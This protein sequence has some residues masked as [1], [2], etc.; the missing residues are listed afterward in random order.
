MRITVRHETRYDYDSELSYAV[1]RLCLTPASFESQKVSS[2]RISAPGIESA[3]NY[4]D[5]F[6]NRI[7]LI[8]YGASDS[9]ISIVAEGTVDVTDSAGIIRRLP[10]AVPDAVFLR[11][12]GAT[13]PNEPMA[14]MAQDVPATSPL[15]RMHALMAEIHRHVEYEIGATHAHTTGAE[16]F[17]EGKGV[18]Q[19]HAHIM[20]GLA[21]YW[22]IPARYVTGYLVTG[23][24]TS[25]T[26]AHAWAE[27][28]IPN[29]GWVGF[30]AANCKCPT[31]HYVRVASGIDAGAVTPVRGSRRGG[32]GERMKV[33][34]RVEI[35]QQ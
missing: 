29:L 9:P 8:T 20:I 32:T 33:E 31:D 1:Q 28:L 5:G 26:A 11:Q 4:L 15:D 22:G 21:R 25:S 23:D 17:V 30:D 6:G 13:M 14:A 34:V 24:D 18:C 35:A 16:A 7:H 27:V 12:T 3:L 19:D 10:S 2:W